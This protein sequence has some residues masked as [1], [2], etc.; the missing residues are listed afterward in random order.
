M[1]TPDAVSRGV[2]GL[3]HRGFDRVEGAGDLGAE[4]GDG[5]DDDDRNECSDEAVLDGG[6]SVASACVRLKAFCA[7]FTDLRNFPFVPLALD[8][9]LL[10]LLLL[11][12]ES[13]FMSL[14]VARR[15]QDAV[16]FSSASGRINFVAPLS[17]VF[18]TP[19]CSFFFFFLIF[20]SLKL[21][22]PG[23]D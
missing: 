17:T 10:L 22:Q 4:R 20:F 9:P 2:Y 14:R 3:G 1:A 11:V 13:C 21:C 8:E 16:L 19:F 23:L 15:S 6:G 5:G 18:K 7:A 12:F